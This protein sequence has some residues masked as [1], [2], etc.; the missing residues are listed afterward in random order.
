MKLDKGVFKVSSKDIEDF[1][2]THKSW[3]S[4]DP[5]VEEFMPAVSEAIERNLSGGNTDIYNRC[6]EA[7]YAA[8]KKYADKKA[9][10]L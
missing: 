6:Y 8:I 5:R 3:W 2:S 10:Q 7:V 1:K 9:G 4:G